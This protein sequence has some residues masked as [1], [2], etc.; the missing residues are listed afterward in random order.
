MLVCVA[1]GL[2]VLCWLGLMQWRSSQLLAQLTPIGDVRWEGYVIEHEWQPYEDTWSF[3]I[4]HDVRVGRG[5]PPSSLGPFYVLDHDFMAGPVGFF[6]GL[7]VDDDEE[8]ELVLCQDGVVDFFLEPSQARGVVMQP[9]PDAAAS[10][11]ELCAAVAR[12]G[13][14]PKLTFV[15]GAALPVSAIALLAILTVARRERRAEEQRS[16]TTF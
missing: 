9:G 6:G 5:H 4:V 1:L 8:L 12:E 3:G 7:N 15:L 11:H 14:R 16:R 13:E 2:F 10:A